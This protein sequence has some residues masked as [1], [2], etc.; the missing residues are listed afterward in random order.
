M[1]RRG[2]V[3]SALFVAVACRGVAQAT[4]IPDTPAGSVIR[5]WQEAFN[6]GDTLR[7]IDYYR[8]FQPE[9]IAQGTVNFRLASGGFDIV[10]IERSEPRHIELVVRERRTPATYYGVVDLA[11]SDPIRVATS[12]LAPMG[13]NADVSQLRVDAAARGKVID[14]ALAQLDSFYVFPDVAKRIAD[15]LHYWNAHG[16]Y[17]SYTKSMSFAVKLNEDVRALSHD[18]HMRVDYSVRPIPPRP[19]TPPPRTP[20]DIAR[21]RA[22]V[23]QVNCAFQKVENLEGNIGYVKFNAFFDVDACAPTATAAMNFVA[24]ARALVIDLRE[25]G[26]GQPA[27]V[28]YIASYLFS[29]RTHL[30]DIWERRSGQTQEFWTRDDVPG[31]KFGGE[32]PV[33]V[34]TSANTFSGGEE[35]T[36]NLKTQKR[37]TIVGETTGGGAHPVSG[38]PIDQHFI[39]GVPFARAI[40]PITHTNWEGTGVEPDVKVPAADALTTA[41]RMIR[42]GGGTRP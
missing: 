7:I 37:A 27:M 14:G 33:Y 8:R 11:P 40:N 1:S 6:S 26:G 21:D 35:F 32:K 24:G 38:H 39:I 9:R 22:Q 13:P 34:L 28:S 25:N 19:A 17:D 20:E 23:D 41:L 42:E 30:N 29:K 15:S 16:R 36:Y 2:F 3:A 5:V 18:K 31:R 4:A 12:T 10:S